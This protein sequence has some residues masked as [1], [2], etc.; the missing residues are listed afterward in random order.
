MSENYY[1]AFNKKYFP[2]KIWGFF[3]WTTLYSDM[4]DRFPDGSTFVEIGVLEGQSLAYLIQ[5]MIIR[6]KNINIIAVD[7]F[8]KK[9]G[10]SLD[11]FN[12]NMAKVQDK[13]RLIVGT[14]VNA[15][16]QIPDDSVDF[17]FID[18]AHDYDNVRDD[19]LAWQPKVK[20]GGVMAGHDYIPTY[21][22]VMRAVDEIFHGQ[23]FKS[24]VHE[25]CWFIEI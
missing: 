14:S 21:P 4:L 7:Y 25:G 10:N 13:F 17:V 8:Q 20:K 6:G 5:E 24:Y 9:S 22:G 11:R 2:N 1:M 18:A 12:K 19:I 15:S 16:K 23:V 3:T